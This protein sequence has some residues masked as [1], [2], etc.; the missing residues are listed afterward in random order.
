M[1]RLCEGLGKGWVRKEGRCLRKRW[2][3]D[4][5][6]GKGT[7]G[8]RRTRSH[9]RTPHQHSLLCTYIDSRKDAAGP[10]VLIKRLERGQGRGLGGGQ[11]S[12]HDTGALKC[13]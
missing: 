9:S 8:L 6:Q 7:G 1:G 2:G 13:V 10:H 12:Q 3:E 5:M 11:I 4:T